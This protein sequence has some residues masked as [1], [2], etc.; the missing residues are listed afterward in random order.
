M[1]KQTK[2]LVPSDYGLEETQATEITVGL[3]TIKKEREALIESFENVIQEEISEDNIPMFKAL[4]IQIR[5]NR[6]KGILPWHKANKAYFYSGGKFVDEIKNREIQ[7][8]ERMEAALMSCEKHF[9]IQEENRLK[10]LQSEREGLIAEFLF[11]GEEHR[12]Y[13][14][15]DDELWKAIFESKKKAH[16]EKL[17]AE[18]KAE[19]ERLAKEKAEEEARLAMVAENE[20]LTKAA[21]EKERIDKIESDKRA[22]IEADRLKAEAAKEAKAKAEQANLKAIS[23][24]KLKAEQ[25]AKKALEVE[26]KAKAQ[27]ESDRMAKEKQVAE[28]AFKAKLEAEQLELKKGDA[29]K[30]KDLKE[31]LE[32]L[33]TKYS[34]SSAKYKK[35]YAD[36]NI[37]IDKTIDHIN[38]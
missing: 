11:E 35:T 12:E 25:D 2:A 28:D 3:S 30:V 27:A 24:A 14:K 13:A 9:E 23:D 36:V 32:K 31:D 26:L 33:K 5:D 18:A 10:E 20:R 34:F 8:N 21:A 38:K 6:T 16:S 4:R 17:E 19:T 15:M 29:E 37:L 7:I 1:E 22:E